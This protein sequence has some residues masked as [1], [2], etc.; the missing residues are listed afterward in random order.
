MAKYRLLMGNIANSVRKEWTA[1]GKGPLLIGRRWSVDICLGVGIKIDK[2]ADSQIKSFVSQS[3][4]DEL[5]ASDDISMRVLAPC[6]GPF[7]KTIFKFDYKVRVTAN[8]EGGFHQANGSKSSS[9]HSWQGITPFVLADPSYWSPWIYHFGYPCN[10]VFATKDVI[11]ARKVFQL[12]T[13]FMKGQGSSHIEG[14]GE[15]DMTQEKM[16]QEEGGDSVFTEATGGMLAMSV[17]RAIYH[18]PGDWKEEP[19]FY[20][21][22]WTARLAPINTHW[23]QQLVGIMMYVMSDWGAIEP[24]MLNY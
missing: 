1:R 2:V 18:R 8:K 16:S 14:N 23:E 6:L 20:N 15:L 4:R 19:N 17:G 12:R 11:A 5:F 21:P 24:W 22:L 13:N 10:M 7:R 9:H 3:R